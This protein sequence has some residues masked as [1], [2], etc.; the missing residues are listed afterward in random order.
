MKRPADIR[1]ALISGGLS[2]EAYLSRRS[3]EVVLPALTECGYQ[4]ELLDWAQ[5][6][7]IV[8]ADSNEIGRWPSIVHCLADYRP[9]VLFNATHGEFENAGQLHGLAELASIPLTGN[10]LASSVMGMDKVRSRHEFARIGVRHPRAVNLEVE[11]LDS[12]DACRAVISE[13]KMTFPLMLKL[14][15]GGS[16]AGLEF[17]ASPDEMLQTLLQWRGRGPVYAE[18]F[19]DGREFC[20]SVLGYPKYDLRVFPPVEITFPGPVFDK[21]AKVNDEYRVHLPA[22]VPESASAEMRTAAERIHR[23]FGFTGLSRVDYRLQGERA[24]AL[25]VNTHPGMSASSI[26]TNSVA[27]A[28]LSIRDLVNQLVQEALYPPDRDESARESVTSA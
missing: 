26:V 9:D 28:E 8:R 13:A 4:V 27:F 17:T 3:A 19:V 1:V 5:E 21:K 11:T 2:E 15:H 24:L 12:A 7:V 18:E 14:T 22:D 20:V 16:S 10:S 23:E 6:E 25:E